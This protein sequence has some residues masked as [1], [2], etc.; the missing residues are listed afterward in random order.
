MGWE[1][2]PISHYEQDQAHV[3]IVSCYHIKGKRLLSE[4]WQEEQMPRLGKTQ[5]R[6]KDPNFCNKVIISNETCPNL[7]FQTSN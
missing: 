1:M 4:S 2:V 3:K 6:D 5:V 7:L